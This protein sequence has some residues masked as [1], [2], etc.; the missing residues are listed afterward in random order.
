MGVAQ[1]MHA[2]AADHIVEFDHVVGV[3]LVGAGL[4][5]AREMLNRHPHAIEALH[6][7]LVGLDHGQHRPRRRAISTKNCRNTK[8]I[9]S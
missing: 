9:F 1:V 2:G 4:H 7:E 5:I 6:V 3:A 8:I